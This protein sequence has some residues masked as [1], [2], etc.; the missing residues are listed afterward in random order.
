[1]SYFF[2]TLELGHTHLLVQREDLTAIKAP[3]GETV[4]DPKRVIF[5]GMTQITNGHRHEVDILA[6]LTYRVA[7]VNGHTHEIQIDEV[8]D[9]VGSDGTKRYRFT[10]KPEQG[11]LQSRTPIYGKLTFRNQ[12]KQDKDKGINVGN[13]WMYR[14]FIGGG[15]RG[16]TNEEAA[17][18][19]FSNLREDMFPRE[20]FE[21]GFFVE[22]NLAVFRTYKAEIEKRVTASIALRNP[23]T[24][25]RVEVR[26][27]DTEEGITKA[28]LIPR[29]FTGSPQ[30]TQRLSREEKSEQNESSSGVMVITPS[31]EL[32][33]QERANSNIMNRTSFDLFTD[34]VAD[35]ELEI[36]LQC[37]DRQQYLGI[38]QSDL[39]IR[40]DDGDVALN[41]VK[42]FFGIW[43]QM[44]ILTAFGVLFSTFLSGPVT[45]IATIGFMVAGFSKTLLL[46]IASNA[47]LG[48][49]PL[50]SIY[51]ILTM[52]NQMND[53]PASYTTAFVKQGDVV[54]SL[55]MNLVGQAIPPLSDYYLYYDAVANGFN[56]SLAWMT[57]HSLVTLAYVVPLFFVGYLILGGREVAK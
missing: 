14:S 44:L 53:L 51:R 42:G 12:E 57:V 40:G 10:V 5:K 38:A 18:F 35:G 21:A 47:K 11:T 33:A 20:Q 19:R 34:F 31:D 16:V 29:H 15:S 50:E 1:M 55:Y 32:A 3:D 9:E 17:I 28:V 52:E 39:Y 56:I 6:D 37:V 26:T 2:V 30:I 23:K 8:A 27:F 36:W 13:E 45:L 41:F 54:Y 7:P 48:G 46:E 49:G 24:G 25:L 43:Q 4:N 22:M